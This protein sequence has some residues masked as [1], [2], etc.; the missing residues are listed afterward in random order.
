MMKLRMADVIVAATSAFAGAG[1]SGLPSNAGTDSTID[2]LSRQ[3][4]RP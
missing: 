4:K 1:I 3:F 2:V